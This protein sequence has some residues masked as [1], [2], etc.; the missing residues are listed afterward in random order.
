[1]EETTP[2]IEMLLSA[3]ETRLKAHFD[4]KINDFKESINHNTAQ[5]HKIDATVKDVVEKTTVNE[6][7]IQALTAKLSA[8]EL[9][10]A[11]QAVQL[12]VLDVR[13]TDQT[14]RNCRNSLRSPQ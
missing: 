4:E 5:I 9:L 1:M 11:K 6:R 14:D 13:Q 8:L 12:K 2:T 7:N 10:C 3:M